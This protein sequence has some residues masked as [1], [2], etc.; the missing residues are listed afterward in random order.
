MTQAKTLFW[1][2][3][4]KI[5]RGYHGCGRGISF[6]HVFEKVHQIKSL[7]SHRKSSTSSRDTAVGTELRLHA[8]DLTSGEL[9]HAA[10]NEDQSMYLALTFSGDEPVVRVVHV[11][12]DGINIT[13]AAG[14]TTSGASGCGRGLG[15]SVGNLVTGAAAATLEGVVESNPVAGFVGKGLER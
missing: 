9:G 14:V 5:E 7:F 15:S 6:V 13:A 12:V 8:R 4:E 3:I 10:A 11:V 1:V 2:S